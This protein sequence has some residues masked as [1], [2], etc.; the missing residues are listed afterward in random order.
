MK[1]FFA[2]SEGGNQRIPLGR[3]GVDSVLMSFFHMFY[4]YAIKGNEEK[5]HKE[6]AGLLKFFPTQGRFLDSGA[7]T[8]QAHRKAAKDFDYIVKMYGEFLKLYSKHFMVVAEMDLFNIVSK[9]EI[10]K[11]REYLRSCCDNP[12]KMMPVWHVSNSFTEWK[13]WVAEYD[14][15]GIGI[16]KQVQIPQMVKLI[17][18]AYEN[19]KKTHGFAVTQMDKLLACPFYS[20]D[21]TTWLNGEMYGNYLKFDRATGKINKFVSPKLIARTKGKTKNLKNINILSSANDRTD[22]GVVAFKEFEKYLTDLWAARGI[23]YQD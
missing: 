4:K 10:I 7:A 9:K 3:V 18:H 23:T 20:V 17:R 22:S 19:G 14:Y 21:S 5:G 12:N 16:T 1:V 8:L 13:D 11:A 6:M 2:G 15:L